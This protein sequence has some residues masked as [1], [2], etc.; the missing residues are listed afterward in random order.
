MFNDTLNDVTIHD[1]LRQFGSPVYLYDMDAIVD[2]Y[3]EIKTVFRQFHQPVEIALSYKTC[4]LL[5]ILKHLHRQGGMAEVVS[6]FEFDIAELL[7]QKRKIINGPNKTDTMLEQS[8]KN[9]SLIN[10]DHEEE[11][12]R[13]HRLAKKIGA[14]VDVGVRLSLGDG[15]NRFGFDCHKMLWSEMQQRQGKYDYLKIRGI[16]VHIGTGLR[17]TSAFENAAPLLARVLTSWPF[18]WPI[19]WLDLGGGLAGIS[20]K[21]EDEVVEHPLPKIASY[22]RAWLEPLRQILET[23]RPLVIMEPGRTLFEPY[24]S[25]LSRVVTCRQRDAQQ[26]S[27]VIDGGINAL[28]TA[29][30]YRHPVDCGRPGNTLTDIYGPLCLQADTLAE[31]LPLPHLNAGDWILIKGVGAYNQSRSVPFIQLR[32]GVVGFS[33]GRWQWLR[34]PEK[35]ADH[36]AL[37]VWQ[38]QIL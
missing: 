6:E 38:E 31:N 34:R 37:E 25:L 13:I 18:D 10:I 15:W 4:P 3:R 16:H 21:W 14:R 9:K 35:L 8:I 2:R 29:R 17:D 36:L 23:H 22:A 26:Q 27:L 20:P 5:G 1:L 28:P 32:P 7:G 24:G 11:F 30:V 33:N 12:S 19:A